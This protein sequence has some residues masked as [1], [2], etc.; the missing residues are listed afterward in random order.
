MAFTSPPKAERNAEMGHDL[1]TGGNRVR[2]RFRGVAVDLELVGI[3]RNSR[4][5]VRDA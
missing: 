5:A 3:V 4:G 2:Q 1:E